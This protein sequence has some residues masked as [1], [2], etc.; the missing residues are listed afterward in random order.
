MGTSRSI[1]AQ[2]ARPAPVMT[3]TRRSSSTRMWRH[4]SR[5]SACM[6]GVKALR[7]S[8]RFNVTQ[9]TWSFT[10]T[11][12]VSKSR[13]ASY[14]SLYP[15]TYLR[16]VVVMEAKAFAEKVALVTGAGSGIGRASALGFARAGAAVAVV[17]TNGDSGRDTVDLIEAEAP[18]AAQFFSC[19][20]SEEDEVVGLV[21]AVTG[22]FGR[23]DAAHN[24]AGISPVT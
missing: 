22:A 1:P 10:S 8:G 13:T 12:M 5:S 21:A 24:N 19:D 6:V 4:T 15:R 7:C 23:L 11:R 20:V 17:D 18:G 2:N 9:H 16:G 14:R 3:A